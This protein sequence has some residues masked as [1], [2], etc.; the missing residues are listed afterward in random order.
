VEVLD[1]HHAR[2][3]PALVTEHAVDG[4]EQLPPASLRIHPFHRAGRVGD[5]QE[6]EEEGKVVLE[7]RVEVEEPTDHLVAGRL[8]VV[9][10]ADGEDIAQ[11]LER[12]HERNGS[13]VSQGVGLPDGEALGA[14]ALGEL[15]AETA[16]AHARLRHHPDHCSVALLRPGQGRVQRR[17][18]GVAADKRGK[19]PGCG[20]LQRCAQRPP[21]HQLPD[22]DRT[23]HTLDVEGT[24]V[25]E[26]DVAAHQRRRVVGEVDLARFGQCLHPLGQADGIP[27]GGVLHPEVVGDR[28]DDDLA[29]VE[30]DADGEG[31]PSLPGQ[32]VGVAGELLPE[33]EGGEAGPPGV[34]LVGD[35]GAEERHDAVAGELVHRSLEPVDAVAEDLEVALHEPAPV[36]GVQALGQFH[37]ADEVGEEHGHVLALTLDGLP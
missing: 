14:T 25:P 19:P 3:P 29:G 28:A 1:E 9:T 21:A 12:H 22:G 7:G 34:I 11:Q 4:G 31:E 13:S 17:H 16:L 33:M 8:V 5:A 24:E 18:L 2:R 32:F 35:R 36:L 10:F 27:D 37:G 30:P 15:V 23:A 6:L 20:H 26:L